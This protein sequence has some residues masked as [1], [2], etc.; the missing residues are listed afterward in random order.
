MWPI[1]YDMELKS[2]IYIYKITFEEIP[3]WYWGVHKEREF[4]E[5]YMGSPVT[6]AWK[7]DFYTPHLQ[8]L[9]VFPYTD[10]G[11]KEALEVEN[12]CIIPDLNN[13]LCLN[14]HCGGYVSLE[15]RRR[16]GHSSVI[17][18][19]R[20]KR[21]LHGM[22]KEE[23]GAAARKGNEKTNKKLDD[24]GKVK[25]RVKANQASN[26][27]KD[28]EGK[29]VN[30]VRRGKVTAKIKYYDPEHPELGEHRACNLSYMQK[31]RGFPNGK[32]NRVKV[33]KEDQTV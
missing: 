3:D 13:P 6:H 14:E 19:R 2:R 11:W 23:L 16:G 21:G 33:Q 27:K 4:K 31:A 1:I 10:E 29:S 7:W 24:R 15:A 30:A 20:E 22:S 12:R 5:F 17:K 26:A 28:F 25:S 9:E 8:I 18:N 32:E